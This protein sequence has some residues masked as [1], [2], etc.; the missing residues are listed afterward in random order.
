MAEIIARFADGRLLVQETRAVESRYCG[1]GV[2]VRIGHI[3]QIEKVLSLTTDHE[4][5]GLI[6]PVDEA[7]VG[8][9]EAIWSGQPQAKADH[10]MVVMRRGDIPT[11]AGTGLTSGYLYSVPPGAGLVSSMTSGLAWLGEVA[12]GLIAISGVVTI[13]ANIIGY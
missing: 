12:S 5:Y 9:Q 4:K 13:K 8:R 6:T 11:T 3:R 1:S 7:R 10:L 2:P